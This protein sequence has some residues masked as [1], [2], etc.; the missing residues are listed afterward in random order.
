MAKLASR[1]VLALLLIASACCARAADKPPA[2]RYALA[3]KLPVT[4][5]GE[6]LQPAVMGAINDTPAVMLVDTGSHRSYLTRTGT[7]KRG[8]A[9]GS[10]GGLVQGIGGLSTVYAA[11]LKDF[12]IGPAHGGRMTLP[13]I[14]DMGS[15]PSFEAIVGADFLLQWD[16]EIALADKEIRFFRPK[17]CGD[18]F[19]GY[20]NPDAVVVPFESAGTGSLNPF[21]MVEVNGKPLRAMID[22][23]ASRSTVTL[24]AAQAAGVKPGDAGVTRAGTFG[25]IG[26]SQAARWSAVFDSF[27]IG[28][29]AIK[30]AAIDVIDSADATG[31]PDVLLG[32]DFLR[33]HRVLIA[34]SQQNVYLSYLG[35]E[36]FS[37]QR[38]GIEPWIVTE[39]EAGNADAQ[40]A[41]ANIYLRSG[42]ERNIAQGTAWLQ[43]AASQ[44]NARANF[45]L[46][47]ALLKDGSYAEAAA[48][49][50]RAVDKLPSDRLFPL[51]LYL[52]R[53]QSGEPAA[54][55]RELEA[56]L[57]AADSRRWPA[58]IA[59][60]YLG[61]IGADALLAK[62]A[63]EDDEPK[64]RGCEASSFIAELRA[65][66]GD[67][68]G[69]KALAESSRADCA[70]PAG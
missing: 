34:M 65:A 39:A 53:L 29:E 6:G 21:F 22:S 62:A 50:K 61:R 14:G 13:V 31:L 48:R 20:W 51:W 70:K 5:T 43:R 2:C 7:D 17:D 16:L 36:V 67:K 58:P 37:T 60:Y 27:A 25:G 32:Q 30:H 44:D 1:G 8:L 66:Q 40:H 57:D 15:T 11:R 38:K 63:K 24:K 4:Y 64:A 3:G 55:K 47:R 41:L 18:T 46:G 23:G 42:G 28:H 52:A 56:N 12:A 69:A 68:D 9:L 45:Q 33:A 49:L 54:A 10:T 35:G 59:A 26:E 19:L